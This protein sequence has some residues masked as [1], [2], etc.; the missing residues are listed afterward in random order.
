METETLARGAPIVVSLAP[1]AIE[2]VRL[3]SVGQNALLSVCPGP[4]VL[5]GPRHPRLSELQLRG[6]R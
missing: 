5:A 3:S 6:A 1:V 2:D 4:P